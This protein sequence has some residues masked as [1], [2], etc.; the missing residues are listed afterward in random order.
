MDGR[1]KHWW[2]QRNSG[3]PRRLVGNNQQNGKIKSV[4]TRNNWICG[5]EDFE[6][7]MVIAGVLSFSKIKV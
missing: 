6:W 4:R 2:N 7:F 5:L 1:G 3:R